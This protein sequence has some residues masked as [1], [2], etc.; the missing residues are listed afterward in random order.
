[1]GQS[2]GSSENRRETIMQK[3]FSDSYSIK[4]QGVLEKKKKL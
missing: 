2:Y 3:K 1:M 4:L